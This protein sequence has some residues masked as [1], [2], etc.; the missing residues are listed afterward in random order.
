MT[1]IKSIAALTPGQAKSAPAPSSAKITPIKDEA[2]GKYHLSNDLKK[3][4]VF[5]SLELAE[6]EI[7]ELGKKKDAAEVRAKKIEELKAEMKTISD[8][9]AGLSP[10]ELVA[11]ATKLKSHE[12]EIKKLSDSEEDQNE[13]EGNEGADED[14]ELANLLKTLLEEHGLEELIEALVMAS[15]AT[16]VVKDSIVKSVKNIA[17]SKTP[18]DSSIKFEDGDFITDEGV[19]GSVEEARYALA[20]KAGATE[21]VQLS[22]VLVYNPESGKIVR[23]DADG[24]V[25][26]YETICQAVGK[27]AAPA[28]PAADSKVID[29]KR[30]DLRKRLCD[31]E[32]TEQAIAVSL[33]ALKELPATDVV[34]EVI[35]TLSGVI[36]DLEKGAAPIGETR[37]SDITLDDIKN[38]PARFIDQGEGVYFDTEEGVFWYD[39]RI[40]IDLGQLNEHKNK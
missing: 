37:L 9:L 5:D 31:T 36:E 28:E 12:A 10:D 16:D 29:S 40:F 27:E 13:D 20:V 21:P 7:V 15:E 35:S 23:S 34:S 4:K 39:G 8:T 26:E 2:S 33:D 3:E 6:A 11:A 25:V 32:S 30:K 24:N 17:D 14:V 18:Y 22:N 38:N 1:L 19:F